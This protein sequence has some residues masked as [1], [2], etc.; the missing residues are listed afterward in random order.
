MALQIT[1]DLHGLRE[2]R[3]SSRYVFHIFLLMVCNAQIR[4]RNRRKKIGLMKAEIK[5]TEQDRKTEY[6]K[7]WNEK[8][9]T[10][11][12]KKSEYLPK[13]LQQT[14]SQ[15]RKQSKLLFKDWVSLYFYALITFFLFT[16]TFF[17]T[18]VAKLKNE[19]RKIIQHNY[20]L[21]LNLL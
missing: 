8:S 12:I 20:S 9:E 2:H 14:S 16:S 5:W 15:Q 7:R 19:H 6:D 10:K 11:T 21:R 1:K 17:F 18:L 3:L 13:A 4:K